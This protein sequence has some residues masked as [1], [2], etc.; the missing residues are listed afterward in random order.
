MNFSTM[1]FGALVFFF[2]WRGYQKG[3]I[4]SITRIVSWLVAYP[5]A[6]YL[7]KPLADLIFKHSPLTGMIVYFIAGS[8]IFLMVSFGV[9]KLLAIFSETISEDSAIEQSSKIGGAIVGI[10]VGGIVGLLAVYAMGL[11]HK[12]T[13][14]NL[15]NNN[16]EEPLYVPENNI[17]LD[18]QKNKSAP[19]NSDIDSF[20]DNSAKKLVSTAAATAIDLTLKDPATTSLT[21]AFAENPQSMLNH[22]QQLSNDGHINTLL[23]DPDIQALLT[24][25]DTN[26]LLNNK[27]F[28]NLMRNED[29]QA[30][31]ASVEDD[32][33]GASSEQIAAEKMTVAWARANALKNDP[34][35]I[36]ILTDPEFQEQLNASNKLPLLTN[37]KLKTLT[38]LIF[39]NEQTVNN[40]HI[41]TKSINSTENVLQP[42]SIEQEEKI[43]G[44]AGEKSEGKVEKSEPKIYQWTDENGKVHY[45]DS[46]IK[47]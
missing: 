27:D 24:K 29:M 12:P 47:I 36:A 17:S 23:T 10:F 8:S 14:V 41:E 4:G 42:S 20:I 38:E 33:T 28:Q 34:Q 19:V 7:T 25:G 11:T 31:L 18:N 40:A 22:I 43:S 5:A 39:T 15:Q 45:S 6:I 35:V 32:K 9:S 46:P 13:T 16:G 30:I 1:V 26:A 21:K 2:V 44:G 3:F 37:P